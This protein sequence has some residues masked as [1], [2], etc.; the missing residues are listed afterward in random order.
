MLLSPK[1]VLFHLSGTPA[2]G[3]A[4]FPDKRGDPMRSAVAAMG[5]KCSLCQK[6][7]DKGWNLPARYSVR[8]SARPLLTCALVLVRALESNKDPSGRGT[9]KSR[10]VC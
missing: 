8:A 9:R 7:S 1:L 4:L 2:A 6:P 5:S 10:G 3:G